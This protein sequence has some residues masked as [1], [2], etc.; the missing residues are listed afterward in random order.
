MNGW[1]WFFVLVTGVLFI[2]QLIYIVKY[3]KFTRDNN[4]VLKLKNKPY[5]K[6]YYSVAGILFL[7]IAI[8]KVSD[9]NRDIQGV[10][11]N[12]LWIMLCFIQVIQSTINHT[13]IVSNGIAIN[14]KIYKW[15]EIISWQWKYEKDWMLLLKVNKDTKKKKV[16]KRKS[17][18]IEFRVYEKY[19]T[20]VEKIL[21]QH[22]QRAKVEE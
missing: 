17:D 8:K 14:L 12:I 21:D 19:K 16:F 4:T 10:V 5:L 9:P 1:D 6:I 20:E 22:I 2:S 11:Y 7:L 3:F 15:S 13:I 18:V